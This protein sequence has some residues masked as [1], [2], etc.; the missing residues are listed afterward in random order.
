MKFSLLEIIKRKFVPIEPEIDLT[1]ELYQ[2]IRDLEPN[3][4]EWNNHNSI[5]SSS[6]AQIH[7]LHEIHNNP[8][9]LRW[10]CGK[11]DPKELMLL[12][13]TMFRDERIGSVT[14]DISEITGLAASKSEL[15]NFASMSHFVETNCRKYFEITPEYL[16]SN[17]AHSEVRI[18]NRESTS[19]YLKIFGWSEKVYLINSGGSHHFA[20]AQYIAKEL[21]TL[22]PV[23]GR[24]DLIFLD[25]EGI[26]R[27]INKFSSLLIPQSDFAYILPMFQCSGLDCVF[28]SA[29]FLPA[30][31]LL[32]FYEHQSLPSDMDSML[33]SKFTDFNIELMK[34]FDIQ[35]SNS[36]FNKQKK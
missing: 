4:A 14:V 30:D 23:T 33:K 31:T 18:I 27:F 9:S 17:L 7:R 11:F 26:N 32:M 6:V 15:Q 3:K 25:R 29:N 35:K 19:D 2:T 28:Y 34:F 13:R 12:L 5:R 21:N 16:K 8:Y 24:M 10:T 1:A 20:S 36:A 22:V